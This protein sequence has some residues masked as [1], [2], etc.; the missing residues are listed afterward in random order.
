MK[1]LLHPDILG[2]GLSQQVD[3]PQGV[4]PQRLVDWL[5]AARGV[6]R[7]TR[8]AV[9]RLRD[10]VRWWEAGTPSAGNGAAMR[11]APVGLACVRDPQAMRT[12]AALSAIP[13]HADPMAVV[14]AVVMAYAT[15]WCAC[16][17]PEAE[18][19]EL[20]GRIAAFAGDLPDPGHPD[21]RDDRPHPVPVRLVDRI[22]EVGDLLDACP[23]QAF[24]HFHNGAFVLESLPAALWCFLRSP[25]DVEE[26]LVTAASGGRDADTV[27]SMAGNLAGAFNGE[28]HIPQRWLDELEYRDDLRALADELFELSGLGPSPVR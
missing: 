17:G 27:A 10:G 15:A 16:R 25:R 6:G 2:N 1:S 8:A 3:Q 12:Q 22:A 18:A 28:D 23:G 5:P 19:T 24:D 20:L 7:A 9:E 4:R 13:T 11:A 26:V 21:R 14:S